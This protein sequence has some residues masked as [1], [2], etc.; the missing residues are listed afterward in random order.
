MCALSVLSKCLVVLCFSQVGVC[1]RHDSYDYQHVI[2]ALFLLCTRW[3]RWCPLWQH[4]CSVAGA[5]PLPAAGRFLSTISLQALDQVVPAVSAEMVAAG[6]FWVM[7]P[8]SGDPTDAVLAGLVAAERA[9]GADVNGKGFKVPRGVGV[10]QV[11]CVARVLSMCVCLCGRGGRGWGEAI[12]TPAFDEARMPAVLLQTL[13]RS[14]N[15]DRTGT[16]CTLMQ[17]DG[18]DYHNIQHILEAVMAAGYSVE[19]GACVLHTL[20][21]AAVPRALLTLGCC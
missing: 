16:P 10:I 6:G 21:P 15:P 3:T 18:I 12:A 13:T 8:D 9:F 14:D 1:R 20:H 17:G 11:N 19:V 5:H 2:C 7:R 4:V